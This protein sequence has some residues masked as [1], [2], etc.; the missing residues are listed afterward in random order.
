[1]L[2]SVLWNCISVLY[3][4]K[5]VGNESGGGKLRELGCGVVTYCQ[6]VGLYSLLVGA[7]I[8][9]AVYQHDPFMC[10]GPGGLQAS[11]LCSCMED[12]VGIRLSVV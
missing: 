8:H 4:G 2:G 11:I 1:M 10:Q 3:Y 5:S 12:V 6:P 9:G 7:F